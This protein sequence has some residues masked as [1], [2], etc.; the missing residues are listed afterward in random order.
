MLEQLLF[1][2]FKLAITEQDWESVVEICRMI[3][4]PVV[5]EL[6]DQFDDPEAVWGVISH[7][8]PATQAEL[9]SY[10]DDRWQD[11]LVERFSKADLAK[12]LERMSHDDRA[13]LVKRMDEDRQAVVM[14]LV[15]RAER[16]D[17]LRLS[18]YEEGTAG[19]IMTTDYA[20]LTSDLT[21]EEALAR[22]RREAPDRETIYYVYVTDAERRLIG[23]VS[24]KDL[25]LASPRKKVGDVMQ[26]D[27]LLVSVNMD[28]EEVANR[29]A[30]YDLIAIPVV[31]GEQRLVGIITHDDIIDVLVEEATE[32]AHLMGAVQPLEQEYIESTL[33]E[34]VSKRAPWLAILLGFEMIA[35]FVL[36][37]HE[38]LLSVWTAMMV[39]LPVIIA[40]GGNT[41]SQAASMITRSLAL[42]EV[43][44]RD[45]FRVARRELFSGLALGGILGVLG[46][47]VVA[48]L[49]RDPKFAVVLFF[50]LTSVTTFG[51]LLGALLPIAFKSVGLDPATSSTPLVASAVDVLGITLYCII[52]GQM[53]TSATN[54]AEKPAPAPPRKSARVEVDGRRPLVDNTR[55]IRIEV[56]NAKTAISTWCSAALLAGV[57]RPAQSGGLAAVS[58]TASRRSLG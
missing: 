19:S 46:A 22:L 1:P 37:L 29:L 48:L 50:G 24:L 21:V 23:F 38:E 58:G 5:A 27:V 8:E 30:E 15:A 56:R 7:L 6:L 33:W 11:A 52:A 36:M 2:D 41:G 57:W 14:P 53:L 43:E 34:M 16:E 25:I 28:V 44:P 51:S 42:G 18:R 26:K 12:L 20:R 31:D 54:D 10:L 45:V 55:R 9:F 49:Y 47:A 40:T 3:H 35:S 17:I 39:F 13:D 4:P 32:D